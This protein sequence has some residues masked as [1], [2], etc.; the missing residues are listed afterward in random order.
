[1]IYWIIGCQV[2][3]FSGGGMIYD[4]L[5]PHAAR[6]RSEEVDRHGAFRRVLV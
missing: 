3:K 4:F 6:S 2:L 1:M 5:N